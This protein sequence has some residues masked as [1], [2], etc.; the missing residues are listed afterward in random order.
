[1]H[2]K[3][4]VIKHLR[5]SDQPLQCLM[6]YRPLQ[7]IKVFLVLSDVHQHRIQFEYSLLILIVSRTLSKR[8][9]KRETQCV[10][11][12]IQTLQCCK[13]RDINSECVVLKSNSEVEVLTCSFVSAFVKESSANSQSIV[14]PVLQTSRDVN[15]CQLFTEFRSAFYLV[16]SISI[17]NVIAIFINRWSSWSISE[18][19]KHSC[20]YTNVVR[21]SSCNKHEL[22]IDEIINW[23]C[24]NQ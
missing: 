7:Q 14:I 10:C 3:W 21:S 23:R 13:V 1:M 4:R 22:S 12:W 5:L 2:H 6:G 19:T 11:Q 8:H 16:R 15:L 20:N 18:R 24:R 9:S 17:L